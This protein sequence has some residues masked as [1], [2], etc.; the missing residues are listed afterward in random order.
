MGSGF[1]V[2]GFGIVLSAAAILA[3]A[4]QRPGQSGLA[5][6]LGQGLQG[7]HHLGRLV[8]I[9]S[10]Y[11]HGYTDLAL[12]QLAPPG[13][14]PTLPLTLTLPAV[15][16]RLVVA[17]YTGIDAPGIIVAE[18]QIIHD[19]QLT[20]YY[21]TIA[22]FSQFPRKQGPAMQL[23]LLADNVSYDNGFLGG[24]IF[25]LPDPNPLPYSP[26]CAVLGQY[27][28]AGQPVAYGMSPAPA[29]GLHLGDHPFYKLAQAGEMTA[30]DSLDQWQLQAPNEGYSVP[31]PLKENPAD[32]LLHQG[33]E[34]GYYKAGAVP[35]IRYSPT[36]HSV[37]RPPAMTAAHE[38]AHMS[39]MVSTAY[40]SFVCELAIVA[41][42][43]ERLQ[44]ATLFQSLGACMQPL[45]QAS[46]LTQEAYATIV[47]LMSAPASAGPDAAA[48][49]RH[50]L[51]PTYAQALD[52][53]EAIVATLHFPFAPGTESLRVA[54]V[55][56]LCS[57][58]L[59]TGIIDRFRGMSVLRPADILAYLSDPA[60]HPDTRLLA[61]RDA[62]GK[63]P[64]LLD[65]VI[66]SL[67]QIILAIEAPLEAAKSQEEWVRCYSDAGR[68]V[69]RLMQQHVR[70]LGL[71]PVDLWIETSM[72]EIDDYRSVVR[73]SLLMGTGI[74]EKQWPHV[75]LRTADVLDYS[76]RQ[77]FDAL[78]HSHDA[79][80]AKTLAPFAPW[81]A[82]VR[83]RSLPPGGRLVFSAAPIP[84][85]SDG[86][87]TQWTCY[88]S[89]LIIAAGEITFN[90]QAIEFDAID[91]TD[92]LSVLDALE[93]HSMPLTV[94]RDTMPLIAGPLERVLQGRA[95]PL[96]Q[97]LPTV[98]PR[99]V[100]QQLESLGGPAR[101]RILLDILPANQI[102]SVQKSGG[103]RLLWFESGAA[104]NSYRDIF[105]TR[106]IPIEQGAWDPGN[107]DDV[108]LALA[109]WMCTYGTI[110]YQPANS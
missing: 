102:I 20:A 10:F 43:L 22:A 96:F 31:R 11:A 2:A 87:R 41:G 53:L 15:G 65:P 48:R 110:G 40:G 6:V 97:Y 49:M 45:M 72:D 17:G 51:P 44:E 82:R 58:V 27:S 46:W 25:S 62:A 101:A 34:L 1:T 4:Q 71:F 69:D 21:T 94:Y 28:N 80:P 52:T 83:A 92:F 77:V 81:L 78:D 105:K 75:T 98:S 86:G 89:S 47:E 60:A 23:M 14:F 30:I 104:A 99:T 57:A 79:L 59:N 18:N 33:L 106:S 19:W 91:E 84:H 67:L 36:L 24:P 38:K 8:P 12:L 54:M 7:G 64:A 26:V 29:M 74:D 85:P 3:A 103:A 5:C 109:A 9:V 63:N 39:L 37:A 42:W 61:L 50:D 56:G 108:D 100:D 70:D 68:T 76:E 73:R 16:T 93:G 35:V 95:F 55:A 32:W 13:P 90:R 107:Q 66:P 88:L